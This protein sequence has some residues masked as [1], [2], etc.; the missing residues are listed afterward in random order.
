MKIGMLGLF[1]ML[2]RKCNLLLLCACFLFVQS[3]PL[4]AVPV[5]ADSVR[6]SLLTCSPGGEIYALFGHTA[7]R[8]ENLTTGVDWVF[9]YG[10]FSFNAPHFVWRF[11]KGDTHYMLGVNSFD[12]FRTEYMERGSVVYGQ[13]LLLSPS[14]KREMAG[15]LLWNS[16][17]ENRTYLYNFFYDNCTTRARDCIENHLHGEVLYKGAEKERSFRDIV[18]EHA[19]DHEWACFGMDLC[20]GSPA[21]RP[22]PLRLQMFA[23]FYLMHAVDSAYVADASTGVERRLARPA[24]PVVRPAAEA[25]HAEHYWLTPLQAAW[26]LFFAVAFFSVHGFLRRKNYAGLDALLFGAAGATGCVIAFLAFFSVHPA[27]SPNYLLAVFHPVHLLYLPVL[28]WRAAK[29][30]RDVYHWAN[31]VVLT[32]FIV[33]FGCFPQ[34]FNLAVLPLAASLWFR[35]ASH[36]A[37]MYKDQ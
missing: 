26:L 16:R 19:V 1:A 25:D 10:M 29:G 36:V 35:S 11:V 18:H 4:K 17:P 23:P 27:V 28:V 32:L 9:N 31:L 34:K 37:L 21:D 33:L 8:Y 14:E 2:M 5:P 15:F 20:L 24:A 6:V 22:V 3:L 13:E 30:K 7:L 12:D